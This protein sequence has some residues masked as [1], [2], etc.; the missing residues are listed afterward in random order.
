MTAELI[1]IHLNLIEGVG[2]CIIKKLIH[3]FKDSMDDLYY[4]KVGDLCEQ[5]FTLQ[6]AQLIVQGL[7]DMS[8]LETEIRLMGQH[9]IKS[10]TFADKQYPVMLANIH[11]PPPVL[12]YK[13]TNVA[14]FEK[15]IAIVG[16]RKANNYA[17][18]VIN[19]WLPSLVK[20]QWTI[21]SG[22]AIGADTMAHRA[23]LENKGN[24]IAVLGSGLLH[25]YPRSNIGMFNEI[26]AQGGLLI[27]CFPMQTTA[28]SH[29]FPVRNR[30]ISGLS[31]ACLVVQAAKKSGASITAEYALEQGRMVF[32]VPGSVFDSLHEGC[33]D[34]IKEG[35]TLIGSEQD[36]L[37]ELGEEADSVEQQLLIEEKQDKLANYNELEHHIIRH[38]AY[39]AVSTDDLMQVCNTDL[40]ALQET[41]FNLQLDGKI[42]Q[43]AVGLWQSLCYI[44]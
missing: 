4:M 36:L 41:L 20:N 35:A 8:I 18:Q 22:G 27:S 3:C 43:N 37:Y 32:T 7:A 44:Q 9:G 1:I 40:H 6:Q 10:I 15:C 25:L 12:Y 21:V 16:S 11:N 23:A 39:K 29:N 26:I 42:D 33:H 17:R 2:P 19:A 38:C 28:Y 14:L 5:G 31:K 30:I 13:G 24:T 34:L